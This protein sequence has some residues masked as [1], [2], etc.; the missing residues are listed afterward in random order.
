[1]HTLKN[2]VKCVIY[3][4]FYHLETSESKKN[5]YFNSKIIKVKCGMLKKKKKKKRKPPLVIF[6]VFLLCASSVL[7][8]AFNPHYQLMQWYCYILFIDEQIEMIVVK[9]LVCGPKMNGAGRIQSHTASD[10]IAHTFYPLYYSFR[11]IK[12]D[13][14]RIK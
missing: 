6:M 8:P 3:L 5:T 11:V 12:L 9:W 7:N 10:S 2:V 14:P 13:R 1:M 4:N